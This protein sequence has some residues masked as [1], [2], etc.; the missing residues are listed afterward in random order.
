MKIANLQESSSGF[1]LETSLKKINKTVV[2]ISEFP[3]GY[4]VVIL[5]GSNLEF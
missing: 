4:N 2:F 5:N 3:V 1:R